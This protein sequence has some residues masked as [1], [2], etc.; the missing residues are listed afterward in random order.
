MNN[1]VV[2]NSTYRYIKIHVVNPRERPVLPLACEKSIKSE[3]IGKIEENTR[4]PK[5][6]ILQFSLT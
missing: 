6:D 1:K 5:M 4:A 3:I 2:Y